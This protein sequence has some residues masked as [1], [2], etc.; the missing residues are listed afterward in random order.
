[1]TK[2]PAPA[3]PPHCPNPACRF[4]RGDKA[5]WRFVRNGFYFRKTAPYRVQ[6]YR[7]DTCRRRFADQTFRPTYWM[8]HGELFAPVFH[9]LLGCSGFRQI[10]REFKGIQPVLSDE[11]SRGGRAAVA[12]LPWVYGYGA[13]SER[14]HD[15]RPEEAPCG[16]RVGAWQTGSACN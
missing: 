6:R 16:A 1:M 11:L 4:H 15:R 7:C 8:H 3:A 2:A 9:R 12:L 13:S 5:L 14:A 10:A